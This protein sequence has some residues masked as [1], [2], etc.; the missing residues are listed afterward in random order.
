VVLQEVAY[1]IRKHLR[2]FDSVYRLGGEEFAVLLA[3]GGIGEAARVAERI[4]DAVQSAPID[5]LPVT[6]SCGIAVSAPNEAFDFEA[7]LARADDAL[8]LAKH[9]GR[10]CIRVDGPENDRVAA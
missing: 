7:V 10:N 2:A 3:G 5:G 1:R 6:V 4:W 8:Y 9:G